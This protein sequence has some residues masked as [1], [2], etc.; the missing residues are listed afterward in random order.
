M[1]EK[2]IPRV[3]IVDDAP[4]IVDT[5]SQL[6]TGMLQYN[7]VAEA[8]NGQQ[9]VD[10]FMQER[11]DLVLLDINMPVKS[12]KD[13]LKEILSEDPNALV[14]M[15]T[16][17]DDIETVEECVSLGAANYILKGTPLMAMKDIIRNTWETNKR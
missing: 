14:I 16:S 10:V 3:L 8:A 5:I 2:S 4:V 9:A 15:L 7:V 6:I 12:G 1:V 13:A 11:P 17:L